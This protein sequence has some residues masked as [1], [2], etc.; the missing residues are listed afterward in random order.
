MAFSDAVK[1]KKEVLG[2][3]KEWRKVIGLPGGR[4]KVGH[5]KVA[6]SISITCKVVY[7]E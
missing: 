2:P 5:A 3:G 6:M 4:A 7:H 1:V